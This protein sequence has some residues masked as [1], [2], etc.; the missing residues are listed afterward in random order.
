MLPAATSTT[1]AVP[2][3]SVPRGVAVAVA[4][5]VVSE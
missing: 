1:T 2:A 3:L 4:V 5:A